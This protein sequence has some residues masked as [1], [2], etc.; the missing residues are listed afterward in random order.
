MHYGEGPAGTTEHTGE[1]ENCPAPSC[2]YADDCPFCE[3]L[4]SDGPVHYASEG[5]VILTPPRP[6]KEGHVVVVSRE[7]TVKDRH[8]VMSA[9]S[10]QA[11]RVS[12]ALPESQLFPE[13]DSLCRRGHVHPHVHVIPA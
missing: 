3:M 7:H 2:G 11:H 13:A 8:D 5:I 6:K 12:R 10:Y 9:L 1:R 4:H